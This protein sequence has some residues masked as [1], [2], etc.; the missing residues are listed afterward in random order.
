MHS[1]EY[2]KSNTWKPVF[3]TDKKFKKG[4]KGYQLVL[5][6]HLFYNHRLNLDSIY[7]KCI[8]TKKNS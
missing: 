8:Y 2:I 4:K 3:E 1:M 7:W 5:D 6:N